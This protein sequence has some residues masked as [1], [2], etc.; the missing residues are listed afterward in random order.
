MQNIL[1]DHG[2]SGKR[3]ITEIRGEIR[4]VK[5]QQ[6]MALTAQEGMQRQIAELERRL[7]IAENAT[8]SSDIRSVDW[9]RALDPAIVR[10]SAD[11]HVPLAAAAEK[12]GQWLDEAG[13]DRESWR[14]DNSGDPVRNITVRFVGNYFMS[15]ALVGKALG[16]IRL[17]T[18]PVTFKEFSIATTEGKH[19]TLYFSRDKTP[20]P[21]C[22]R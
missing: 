17:A 1:Q 11:T 15:E 6:E 8:C 2:E 21:Y 7:G 10:V 4:D 9:D 18:T 22:G 12:I 5:D 3:Q 20:A 19:A 16:S 13:I 14:I